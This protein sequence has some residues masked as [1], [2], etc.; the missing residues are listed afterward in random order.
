MHGG[1]AV[2]DSDPQ[3][4]AW[5][6][7]AEQQARDIAADPAVKAANL[8][9]GETWFVG[10]D[11]LPNG[12]DGSIAGVPLTGPWHDHIAAPASWHPAQLS[13][14]YPGYPKQDVGESDANHRYRIT[15]HAA[16]VDGLLPVG[17]AR[18]R[19][20]L[21]PHAFILG[22][23]LNLSN[24]APLM[25]WPG[26]HRIMGAAFRDLIGSRD[27]STVDLTEGYQV[28]RRHVFETITPQPVLANP[29]TSILLHRHLLHGV[30][31]WT[32]TATAPPEGR[33]IAYFRPQFSAKSW[34]AAD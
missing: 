24:A 6:R 2:F 16:H 7:A 1:F 8:R 30:A 5:A 15:R 25:V 20:L 29:G 27:P 28:A 33:M 18:R 10:V 19:F 14:V 26:S 3:V 32:A 31:P 23:P 11:A 22:L 12:P 17:P 9:H 34:L 21:E 4:T 13:I